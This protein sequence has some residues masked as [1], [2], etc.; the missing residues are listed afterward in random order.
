[1]RYEII[2]I[3]ILILVM[4]LSKIS[5]SGDVNDYIE[6]FAVE[7]EEGI[8]AWT[9]VSNPQFLVEEETEEKSD[10]CEKCNDTGYI[11][12]G[13]GRRFP[14]PE[15]KPNS[16]QNFGDNF[17]R[18]LEESEPVKVY[19]DCEY[20]RR[21]PLEQRTV[22]YKQHTIQTPVPTVKKNVTV[23]PTARNVAKKYKIGVL[24]AYWCGPCKVYKK[25]V[26]KPSGIEYTPIN[27]EKIRWYGDYYKDPANARESQMWYHF[28]KKVEREKISLS[29]PTVILFS[30]D[31]SKIEILGMP[32]L[33]ELR[34]YE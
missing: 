4:P 26:L 32:K 3:L 24:T 9:L 5:V 17:D 20:C 22:R 18:A 6:P 34:K 7:K 1:M 25:N 2:I 16:G 28:N 29:F 27:Y 8:I 19:C 31:Y 12:T 14:C 15:C 33:E 30:D 10:I 13:D 21:K 23:P 11:T